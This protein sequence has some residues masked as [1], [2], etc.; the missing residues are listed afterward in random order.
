[1][2]HIQKKEKEEIENRLGQSIS[3]EFNYAWLAIENK[4][5]NLSSPGKIDKVSFEIENGWDGRKDGRDIPG[6]IYPYII[7][8]IQ[9]SGDV[10]EEKGMVTLIR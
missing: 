10:L 9:P 7:R 5:I 3:N 6:G 8:L 2:D 1:M 4:E